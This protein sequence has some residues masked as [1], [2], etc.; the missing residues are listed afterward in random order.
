MAVVY[1]QVLGGVPRKSFYN[2]LKALFRYLDYQTVAGAS[3]VGTAAGTGVTASEGGAHAFRKTT[4]TLVNTPLAL[5][6]EA[7]V[8]AYKGLKVY[9][10]PAGSILFHGARINCAV[11]KSSAGVIDTWDGDVGLGTVIASNNATLASTEQDLCP[12]TATPQAVGGAT[13][14]KAISTSTE[15]AKVFANGMDVYLNALVDDADHDVTGTPCNLI[16]NG[17]ID[18]YWTPLG[19][20]A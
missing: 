20:I 18:I 8:V 9:D 19:S 6:D 2:A 12:T 17:T 10:M 1:G 15:A 3:Q 16:F 14:A 13:T 7:G 11:T 4:L 5:V